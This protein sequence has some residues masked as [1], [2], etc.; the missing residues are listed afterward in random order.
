MEDIKKATEK[1]TLTENTEP[2][3]AAPAAP[4]ATDAAQKPSKNAEKKAQKEAEKAKKRAERAAATAA[5]QA[6]KAAEDAV[7]VSQGKYGILPLIQSAEGDRKRKLQ[8]SRPL[9][10]SGEERTR[11]S[12]INASR[13][14]VQIALRARVHNLRLQGTSLIVFRRAF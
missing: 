11:I 14:G 4:P 10:I 3:A 2:E 6:A 8:L 9:T 1:V 7:D 13:D 5:Q 12:S